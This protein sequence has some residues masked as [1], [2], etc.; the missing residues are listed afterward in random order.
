VG[1]T[2][3]TVHT[4]QRHLATRTSSARNRHRVENG[5][6]LGHRPDQRTRFEAAPAHAAA[7][8][9]QHGHL[10]VPCDAL[11]LHEGFPLGRWLARQRN[12]AST[13]ARRNPA[14][15]PPDR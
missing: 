6:L 13:R 8:A 11:L 10:A 5:S 3:D 4:A 14:A 12:Q 9:A 1:L 15:F 2:P 7:Y